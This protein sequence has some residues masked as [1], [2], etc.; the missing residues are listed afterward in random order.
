MRLLCVRRVLQ[1]EA[2]GPA[3]IGRETLRA[4][5]FRASSSKL[6]PSDRARCRQVRLSAG[7]ARLT[8]TARLASNF[9]R[10]HSISA[11]MRP[12]PRRRADGRRDQSGV[13]GKRA[14]PPIGRPA[15]GG[16]RCRT[17][18]PGVQ[19]KI[20]GLHTH[21]PGA[22]SWVGKAGSVCVY[23][24]VCRQPPVPCAQ[25]RLCRAD[26][27]GGETWDG[28]SGFEAK[29]TPLLR[30][31]ASYLPHDGRPVPGL[32]R[33]GS[34]P[35]RTHIPA[36]QDSSVPPPQLWRRRRPRRYPTAD[37][38]PRPQ[39]GTR[40]PARHLHSCR[41]KHHL[42]GHGTRTAGKRPTALCRVHGARNVPRPR[43]TASRRGVPLAGTQGARR[44][45]PS[46]SVGAGRR[47]PS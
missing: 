41:G 20:W 34:C 1:R 45:A 26:S 13:A 47:R 16:N 27:W 35:L 32:G 12:C 28:K 39:P 33:E 15:T 3:L 9:V 36:P 18:T 43:C 40:A 17:T 14:A 21:K 37:R 10:P 4:L 24:C 22:H 23:V 38:A 44:H 5:S 25:R 6:A 8:Q 2:L 29:R 30:L 11:G 42:I 46:G 7:W 19:H 31:P